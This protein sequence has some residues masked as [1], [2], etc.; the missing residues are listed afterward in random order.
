MAEPCTKV[1]VMLI[2]LSNEID[3]FLWKITSSGLFT[4]KSMYPY[5]MNGHIVFL[6]KLTLALNIKIFVWFLY[7]KVIL[8]TNPAKCY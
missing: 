4:V 6:S 7:M 5:M 3:K 2:Q 8:K 1:D